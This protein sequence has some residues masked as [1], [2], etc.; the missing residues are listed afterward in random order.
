WRTIQKGDSDHGCKPLTATEPRDC[1]AS[2]R[3]GQPL[4]PHFRRLLLACGNT[5]IM[6]ELYCVSMNE[7]DGQIVQSLWYGA[8][9]GAARSARCVARTI[10]GDNA[11]LRYATATQRLTTPVHGREARL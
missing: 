10:W 5:I 6:S 1:R 4:N 2:V 7:Q 11:G 8:A 3:P 9:L